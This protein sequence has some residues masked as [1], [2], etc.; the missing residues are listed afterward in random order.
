MCQLRLQLK[1][2]QE[3]KLD[4]S[5]SRFSSN[6]CIE[7]VDASSTPEQDNPQRRPTSRWA[8][9]TQYRARDSSSTPAPT[10]IRVTA[11][12]KCETLHQVNTT[13]AHSRLPMATRSKIPRRCR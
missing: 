4:R 7:F 3:Q 8:S 5:I 9:A 1:S 2:H 11:H 12:S 13:Y 6:D 10:T